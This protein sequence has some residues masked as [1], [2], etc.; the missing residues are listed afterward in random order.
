MP[1]WVGRVRAG[2]QFPTNSQTTAARSPS[3][4]Q[5]L[6]LLVAALHAPALFEVLLPSDFALL[7]LMF[8][9]VLSTLAEFAVPQLPQH[10]ILTL[11]QDHAL[12]PEQIPQSPEIL[13]V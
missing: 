13:P 12:L 8:A 1:E 2:I 4:V 10:E 5:L 11:P 3:S 6:T 7:Q 9:S